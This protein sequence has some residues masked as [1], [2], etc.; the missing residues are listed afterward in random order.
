MENLLAELCFYANK[1]VICFILSHFIITFENGQQA[2]V[3][4]CDYRLN[5]EI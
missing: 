4:C 1:D 5:S 3:I 2:L